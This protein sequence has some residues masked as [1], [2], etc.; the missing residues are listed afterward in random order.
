[1]I[2][3]RPSILLAG[4]LIFSI[5]IPQAIEAVPCAL[6]PPS[7][8]DQS[9]FSQLLTAV[10]IGKILYRMDAFDRLSADIIKEKLAVLSPKDLYKTE[11][12]S[13]KSRETLL[14]DRFR[15]LNK[16]EISKENDAELQKI[17]NEL[18]E[19][20]KRHDSI[21]LSSTPKSDGDVGSAIALVGRVKVLACTE[22]GPIHVGDPI[23]SSSKPGYAMKATKPGPIVGFSFSELPSGEGKIV[24]NVN[25]SYY[26]PK[27]EKTKNITDFGVGALTDASLWISFSEDFIA[28]I[29]N[30]IPVVTVTP[31]VSGVIVSVTEIT[32]KGFRVACTNLNSNTVSINWIAISKINNN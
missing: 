10:R 15:L 16:N 17:N 9:C 19:I 3:I 30:N 22:N 24:V 8:I 23:T 11:I 7:I 27:D 32:N 20:R 28:Q 18:M 13:L 31:N 4:L 12:K 1:M 25:R 6:L 21:T 29:G 2:R 26:S 5:L 14:L